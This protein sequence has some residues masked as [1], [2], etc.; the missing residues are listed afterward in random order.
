MIKLSFIA[1]LI[2]GTAVFAIGADDLTSAF[3]EGKLEGN[4]RSQY[5]VTEWK[6][7]DLPT[8]KGFALGGSL[9]YQTDPLSGLSLGIG[10]YT[11][12][13]PGDW[14][15]EEDGNTA[16]TSKDLFSRDSYRDPLTGAKISDPYGEGYAVLAQSYLLY[17]TAQTQ[18][19]TGRILTDKTNPW[20]TPNDT[21]MI[22]VAIEGVQ[23]ISN[24]IANT[25]LSFCY[26]DKIKERGMTYFGNM[27]DTLDTPSKISSYYSTHYGK[28]VGINGDAP[29]VAIFGVTNKSINSLRFDAWGMNWK[30]LASQARFEVGYAI[31][32]G[33]SIIGLGG[34]YLK[35]FDNG[36]GEI[37]QPQKNNNDSDNSIDTDLYALRV[38]V[39]HGPARL[40]A[41]M[42]NTGNEGDL[43][44]PWR[45]FHTQGYTRSMTQTDWNA[46]TKARK[47]QLDYNFD[48]YIYSLSAFLSYSAYNRNEQKIPYQNMTDRG[49][50][51]GDTDQWNMD[52][53]YKLSGQ[54]K[55]CELKLRLMD[56]NNEATVLHPHESSNQE[57]RF[58]I[59]YKF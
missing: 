31:E 5:F 1:A 39:D 13:N 15:D 10:L 17:K 27:A 7:D 55:G 25:T 59:S 34:L 29:G 20:I 38:S 6:S 42:S 51:N 21:K 18:A 36:A 11:T 52:I 8:A 53:L 48:A 56:Q 32:A 23:I 35:Q 44:A 22:P 41:A 54:Y 43:L 57:T 33:D 19:K 37:I 9:I 49:L 3:K 30:N 12:Q 4:I 45:G 58:E 26:A 46:D 24:D 28:T 2:S 16:T 40:M 14:T 47:I 50:Q